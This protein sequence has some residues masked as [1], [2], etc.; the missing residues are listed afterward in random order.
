MVYLHKN[1]KIIRR[2]IGLTQ[3]EIASHCGVTQNTWSNYENGVSEPDLKTLI[4]ISY[5]LNINIDDL[6]RLNFN[7]VDV[8]SEKYALKKHQN[9]DPIVDPIVDPTA[10]FK[11]QYTEINGP[12]K[13]LNEPSNVITWALMGQLKLMDGKLD[14]IRLLAE[15]VA[16][17]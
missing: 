5:I 3:A 11:R 17:K 16:N 9:V 6:I 8:I 10:K 4:K 2:K 13:V 15:K 1:I 7:N 14:Q 12:E